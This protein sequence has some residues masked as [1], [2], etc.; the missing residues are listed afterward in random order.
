ME[1]KI[2]ILFKN[3]TGMKKKQTFIRTSFPVIK[4]NHFFNYADRKLHNDLYSW[5]ITNFTCHKF[6]TR[7]WQAWWKHE[8]LLRSCNW[9]LQWKHHHGKDNYWYF[10][11]NGFRKFDQWPHPSLCR[12][13][14]WRPRS[15]R[16]LPWRP[17]PRRPR[18]CW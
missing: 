17:C 14:P 13:L 11:S 5:L 3:G 10:L 15:W 8:N 7:F 1:I 4:K 6:F 12:S 9:E 18:L 16:P 2:K